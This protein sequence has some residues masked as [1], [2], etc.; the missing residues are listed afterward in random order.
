MPLRFSRTGRLV[1]KPKSVYTPIK[2]PIIKHVL[3]EDTLPENN[4][5]GGTDL[6]NG[7]TGLC[8]EEAS[9]Y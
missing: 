6:C 4:I 8:I 7:G 1:I 2:Q 5:D 9:W 3:V